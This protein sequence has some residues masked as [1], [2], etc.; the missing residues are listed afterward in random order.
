ME[1]S[2]SLRLDDETCERLLPR[3]FLDIMRKKFKDRCNELT[4]YRVI[5]SPA[6]GWR[7]KSIKN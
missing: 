1:V 2:V 6:T 7:T 3:E 5:E 4:I